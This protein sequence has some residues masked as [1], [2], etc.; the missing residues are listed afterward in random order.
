M[1]YPKFI[2]VTITFAKEEKQFGGFYYDRSDKHDLTNERK[3]NLPLLEVWLSDRDEQ[4]AQLLIGALRDAIL[5]GRKYAGVRFFKKEGEGLM[6][7]ADE[8]HGFSYQSR[9]SILGLVTW[10]ELHA[11]RLP[12]WSL[13]TD[14]HDFSLA[15][16]PDWRSDLDSKFEK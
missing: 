5:S 2:P 10:Q 9:Y 15:D 13:P 3:I 4:K 14:Y 8:E 7:P 1:T 11:G 16:L 12:K 6:T